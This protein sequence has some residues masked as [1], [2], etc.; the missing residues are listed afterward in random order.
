MKDKK[1]RLDEI[2][3]R[4]GLISD[5]QVQDALLRQK[6]QGGKLGSQLLYHHYIDEA[7]LVRALALQI[8]CEGVVLSDLAIPA[9]ILKFIPDRVAVARKVVPF[10]YDIK[11]NVLKVACEDPTDQNLIDELNFVAH[12]TQ[13]KLYL[14]AEVVL[15]TVI[16]KYYLGH[17]VSPRNDLLLEL[18]E[19]TA[20]TVET[21]PEPPDSTQS[22][23][24]GG[25]GA[26]LLVSD[27]ES[28][29][30]LLQSL[31]ER[32]NYQ[33]TVTDSADAA[34]EII[35]DKCFHT[36]FVKDTVSGDYI[37]LI[38][39]LRKLSPKTRVRYY[40]SASA[41]LLSDE[42]AASGEELLRKNLEIFTSLLASMGNTDSNHSGRVGDYVYRLCRRLGLPK[43]EQMLI[44]NTA[45]LHDLSRYYYGTAEEESYRGVIDLSIKLL[46]SIGYSPVAIEMLRSMYIDL[47][48][49]YTRRLPIE[50][51][52]G[53]IITIV[54]LFCDNVP[55]DQKLS[56]DKFDAIKKKLRDLTGRLFL[57]EV[58]E[59]FTLMVQE[60]I[61]TAS[62][63]ERYNQVV[64]FSDE[65]ESLSA[66]ELRLKNE[67]FRVVCESSPERFVALYRRARPD[68]I[69][70][71]LQKDLSEIEAFVDSISAQGIDI[72][73]V[74]TFLL[75]DA[76]HSPKLTG[77]LEKGLHDVISVDGTYDLLVIK[78]KKVR[79]QL[80]K[81]AQQQ[82]DLQSDESGAKGR[83]TDMNL[84]D[85]LQALGPSRKTV[86]IIARSYVP[87]KY[88]LE[89]YL[90]QGS[91]RFA[92]LGDL[93][94]AQAIYEAIAWSDG[95]WKV[96]SV[97]PD[98]LPECNVVQPNESI[99][100]EGCRLLD[101]KVRTGQLLHR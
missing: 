82:R 72:E 32:D 101:E 12:G 8:G 61:L 62:V 39:R 51:L 97:S 11:S 83:L 78:L 9:D 36:V 95:T 47:K 50:V 41:L 69:I 44:T 49:K 60:E 40:E 94:G 43:K 15:N 93:T 76:G 37:D 58:A 55:S 81:R 80:E 100:M 7:G 24:A 29:G 59:A 87:D 71:L 10:Q 16:A 75:A 2:L 13:V 85:L 84:I 14:A 70:L 18:P 45:Y 21:P 38:D 63:T 25:A 1:L 23:P 5:E 52:G 17:D 4:E 74:P 19:E 91:I 26:V 31:L 27:E 66:A 6:A 3:V 46:Q 57:S 88:H 98:A 92:R 86:R 54:D 28:S 79:Q 68:I 65:K 48:G 56:L 67:G 99:L 90:D 35:G 64:M 34:I 30:S 53:N 96:E 77:L 33:V 73:Q 22:P 89:L 20:P 42:F